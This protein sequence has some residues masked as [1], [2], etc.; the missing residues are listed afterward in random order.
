MTQ[1]LLKPAFMRTKKSKPKV[2]KPLVNAFGEVIKSYTPAEVDAHFA[3][4]LETSRRH[5][6]CRQHSRQG[7][8]IPLHILVRGHDRDI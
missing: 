4:L 8:P 5:S 2:P 3:A 6:A 7:Q 1:P